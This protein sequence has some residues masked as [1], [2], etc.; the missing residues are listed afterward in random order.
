MGPPQTVA[1]PQCCRLF[2]GV[3]FAFRFE[4]Q[5]EW[6]LASGMGTD[7]HNGGMENGAVYRFHTLFCM[8]LTRR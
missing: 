2:W 8:P 3:P 4:G 5:Q 1:F 6:E 7:N